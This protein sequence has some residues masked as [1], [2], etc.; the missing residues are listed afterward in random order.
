M[1]YFLW[2]PVARAAGSIEDAPDL[3]AI[4]FKVLQF[5]LSVIGIV[6]IIG[7]VISGIWYLT[8]AGDE[9]RMR[10]AKRALLACL[11]GS[12]IALGALVIVTQIGK[13]FA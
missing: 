2:I 1:E 5:L 3:T 4:L 12:V 8:A 7:L 13:W 11:I 6:G 10:V 9:S